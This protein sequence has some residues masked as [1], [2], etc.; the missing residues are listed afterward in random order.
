MP[1]PSR[2]TWPDGAT[3]HQGRRK[4]Q[5]LERLRPALLI[6]AGLLAS[7]PAAAQTADPQS[8]TESWIAT[9][10]APQA[11]R[12]DQPPQSLPASAQAY[13]WVRDVPQ[14]VRDVAPGQEPPVESPV[15]LPV[16]GMS[17]LQIRN[18]TLRQ[19]AH[20]SLGGPRVRVVLSNSLGILPLRV[21]AAH[22]ALRGSGVSIVPATDH[23]LTFGGLAHP[24]IPP[25]PCWSAIPSI[26]PC[27]MAVTWRWISICRTTCPP[28]SRPSACITPPGR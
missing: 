9:W 11:A 12:V 4:Q 16:G 5:H 28:G 18:Q 6:A 21:G 19:I 24:T 25:A 13:P 26:S 15:E 27:P 2:T 8:G 22:V 23:V 3:T 14:A 1:D 10:A 17:P 7:V 20:V